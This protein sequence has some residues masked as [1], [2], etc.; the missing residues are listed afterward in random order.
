[1]DTPMSSGLVL[2]EKRAIFSD[3]RTIMKVPGEP[4]PAKPIP[5]EKPGSVDAAIRAVLSAA[6]AGRV[7]SPVDFAHLGSRAAID[8]VL[9]RLTASGTIRRVARGLYDV[10]RTHATMGRLL[11]S[12]EE[13]ASAIA[14]RGSLRLQPSGA[15]AANLLGLTEQ[16]PI[17]LAFLTDGNSRTIAIGSQTIILKHTTPRN[18]ATAGRIS[19]MAIQAL[20][21][22]GRIHVDAQVIARLKRRLTPEDRAVL[23]DDAALAPAWIADIMRH[24]AQDDG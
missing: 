10:P 7:F 20:R 17:K 19:G 4:L 18:M 13:I 12:T 9:S 24:V 8:K 21:H 14:N 3:M 22:L 5:A 16:V 6:G 23:Q 2:S 11:P 15:Y 1:M